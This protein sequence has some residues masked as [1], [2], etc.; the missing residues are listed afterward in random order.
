M[1][2]RYGCI[3]AD[4]SLC[5]IK[6]GGNLSVKKI[7][8]ILIFFGILF[9]IFGCCTSYA[10]NDIEKKQKEIKA[11][12]NRVQWLE[13]LETNKLY[14]NQQKLE[15]AT[16]SLQQS[17]TQVLTAEKELYSMQ[18]QLETASAEYMS[19]NVVLASH[20]RKIFKSQRKAFFELFISAEDINMLVDRVYFQKIILKDDYDR[21]ASAKKK[22]Q[23]I[24]LL[25]LN[26]KNR[27]HSLERSIA[28]INSQQAYI[29][30]AISKNKSMIDKLKTDKAAY[31]KAEK[32]L[33]RQSENIGHYISR[34]TSKDSI[35]SAPATGFI[36]PIQG[37]ITSPYGW[38]I[39][40]IFNTRTFHSG[41][42]IG[43][44]NYGAIKASNSGKVI[45]TGW[46]GGYGKVVI[47]EH[48][49]V[50]GK[51]ISTLYAH[52]SSIKVSN[53][54]Q[55]TKGQVVGY[56]GTTGYSTGPH[57]HFE[58]RVNGKTDNPLSY[59]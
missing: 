11:K 18:S 20:V 44:P 15:N 38:R 57:C 49:K 21:M 47:I 6:I 46:Y 28:S 58:V 42:D 31:Q 17:K 52:M 24:A 37:R 36:K 4:S 12:I 33:A 51:P 29:Q 43:G 50:N 8:N 10:A 2:C 53:G 45:Y 54:Q 48:G 59:I 26:I 14:K 30:Q 23:E 5:R 7:L 27:K 39:H 25:T 16:N 56:E 3:H 22:A 35:A 55:V 32:E 13:N 19:L 9:S 40:P 41:V 1:D 34:T